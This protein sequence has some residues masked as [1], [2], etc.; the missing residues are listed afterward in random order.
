M[1]KINSLKTYSKDKHFEQQRFHITY[2]KQSLITKCNSLYLVF[3]IIAEIAM[4]NQRRILSGM[5]HRRMASFLMTE[6]GST[7]I[8]HAMKYGH[9]TNKSN[10]HLSLQSI[11][12][13][14]PLQ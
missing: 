2:S 4:N 8:C 10:R 7:S 6:R 1:K 14:W 11:H 5:C 9:L 3:F 13:V 12:A